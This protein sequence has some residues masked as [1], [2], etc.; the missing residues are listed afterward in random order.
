M[1]LSISLTYSQFTIAMRNND[2]TIKSLQFNSSH[3]FSY[4]QP[5][6]LASEINT[7]GVFQSGGNITFNRIS[8]TCPDPSALT[9][10]NI[11]LTS[12]D[13]GWT[14][15]ATETMWNIEW[16]VAGFTLGTGT[17]VAV[18]TN[19]HSL[20]TLTSGTDYEFYVQADCGSGNRSVWTGPFA[21]STPPLNDDC[22]NAEHITPSTTGSEVWITGTTLGNTASN[23]I[24]LTDISCGG[25][26]F[27]A[28]RD[29]WFTTEVPA[30][31][32]ITITTQA[33]AGSLLDD[34][35]L[36]VWSGDCGSLTEID[37]N[38]S[39]GNGEIFEDFSEVNLTGLTAGNII[40][41]RVSLHGNSAPTDTR[42]GD[43]QIATHAANPTLLGL[44]SN[45]IYGF[46]MVPNPMTTILKF[47]ALENI[48]LISIFN[49]LGQKVIKT[50]PNATETEFSVENLENGMYIV[51]VK[52]GNQFGVYKI[53]KN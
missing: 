47:N 32:A 33:S 34:T 42:D 5:N 6:Y 52:V 13:L 31:G 40:Y 26:S 16:G 9:A 3:N 10:T 30:A 8:Q 48:Q 7:G 4:S 49:L 38:D 29:V 15:G 20:T 46:S 44:N 25:G 39:D 51:K 12:A 41:I 35:V 36:S 50:S 28:G 22:T 23:E 18:T 37:C 43:F 24:T 21:F 11:T 2:N 27:G 45:S 53:L 19:S 17:P 14:A 1:I